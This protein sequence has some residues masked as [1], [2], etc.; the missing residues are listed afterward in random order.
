MK[1]LTTCLAKPGCNTARA[2]PS[3]CSPRLHRRSVTRHA[4]APAPDVR[5]AGKT[6]RQAPSMEAE[7][8]LIG[9]DSGASGASASAGYSNNVV[10]VDV[11]LMPSTTKTMPVCRT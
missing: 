3:P 11:A 2:A 4:L 1:P 9:V 8:E 7:T 5:T 6:T 10:T